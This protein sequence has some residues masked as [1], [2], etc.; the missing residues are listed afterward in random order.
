MSIEQPPGGRKIR[1]GLHARLATLSADEP[2]RVIVRY[3]SV[4][5]TRARITVRARG[6]VVRHH[7]ELIPA[8]A[9][10]ASR[11][12]VEELAQDPDVEDVWEDLPVHTMLDVS[13]P[14]IRAPEVWAEGYRGNGIKV[15]V[16][17]TGID[18][19]HPDF[20]GRVIA[21]KGFAS[22]S[23]HDGH[24]HGTHVAS[25]IA[26]SGKAGNGKYVGIAPEALLMVAKVLRDDGGGY[27]SDV[28]AGV[29]W[30]VN[31]GAQVINLSLGSDGSCDG[32]DALSVA[33]DAAV[34]HGVVVCVAAGN[35]GPG[36]STVGSPGCARKVITVGASTDDDQIASF[37][38]RGPTSDGRVKPDIVFPGYN[39]V[40]ARASG[41]GMG[42]PVNDFYTSASGTSMATPHCS[43]AAAL[44]LEAEPS[45]TPEQVAERLKAGAVDLGEDANAQGAGRADVYAAIHA[46]EGATPT[47]SPTP[48]PTPT[49]GPT[50]PGPEPP[51][52]PPPGCLTAV[53]R[54]LHLIK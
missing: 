1:G 34:S 16:V 53:L 40:A 21:T 31:Q 6:I 9:L 18:E 22:E 24:G 4:E 44:L 13:V 48:E 28:I 11:Q 37:S 20:E 45:L 46:G 54:A 19:T 32:T 26:G 38:S 33:C 49:P 30:A 7:Y 10:V 17:D 23:A 8:S 50:P 39:I 2:I 3:R 15:A 27:M 29:E 35:A 41:T 14:H 42:H 25:I 51:P 47:P 12:I 52:E 43:G 36:G 5:A